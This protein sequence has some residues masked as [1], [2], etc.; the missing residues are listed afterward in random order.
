[1]SRE[2]SFK[3]KVFVRLNKMFTLIYLNDLRKI[4]E[5]RLE[6][7]VTGCYECKDRCFMGVE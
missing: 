2:K 7:C 3:E 5:R 4:V 6:F 1:M